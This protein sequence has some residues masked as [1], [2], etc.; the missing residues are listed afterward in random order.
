MCRKMDINIHEAV[1]K[2]NAFLVFLLEASLDF[3]TQVY[4]RAQ[5]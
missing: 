5:Q 3:I 1:T 2:M 4:N